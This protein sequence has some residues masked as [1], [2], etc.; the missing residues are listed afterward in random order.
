[1]LLAPYEKRRNTL[2]RLTPRPKCHKMPD[3]DK[4]YNQPDVDVIHDGERFEVP[5]H[6]VVNCSSDLWKW[7]TSGKKQ[8]WPKWVDN[9]EHPSPPERVHG[10]ELSATWIGHATA[11]IQ[12]AGLNLLT[13]PFFSMRASPFQWAGP[14]RVRH[15]GVAIDD[16]PPIDLILLSHNHYDHM[17]MPT[18]RK[19]ANKHK[20]PILTPAGNA[21][22]V[23]RWVKRA[24]V[25]ERG[26]HE[27]IKLNA[28]TV[29]TPTPA[30]HWSKRSFSDRNKALWSA[31]WIKAGNRNIYFAADTGFGTG[32][33]FTQT[34][35]MY[36]SPD[37]ALI[38]IGAYEPRWFM[39]AQH[40]DPDEAVR[41]HNMLG[42]KTSIGIHHSTIQL[43]DEA[44]DDPVKALAQARTRHGIAAHEFRAIEVG[45]TWKHDA[46]AKPA[47]R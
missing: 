30:L 3:S 37:L 36:G 6:K 33:H 5:S 41:A 12:T 7:Q 20:A 43:T 21:K 34:K 4:S 47:K 31:F 18:L 22:I 35:E 26:W 17:D 32:A 40:I 13:D 25:I 45:E 46:L 42:A 8:K 11:L 38:P 29:I 2:H 19:L 16:L 9:N 39:K 1:M 10:D 23:R 28:D 14:K 27:G 44:I 15:P 24:D